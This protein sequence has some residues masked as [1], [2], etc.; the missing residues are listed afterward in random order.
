[1]GIGGGLKPGR[2]RGEKTHPGPGLSVGRSNSRPLDRRFSRGNGSPYDLRTEEGVF[3]LGIQ[4]AENV[5]ALSRKSAAASSISRKN[6]SAAAVSAS[7]VFSRRTN[8]ALAD[9][10]GLSL[11][12][13][14][15]NAS[16]ALKGLLTSRCPHQRTDE[17]TDEI[18]GSKRLCENRHSTP[19]S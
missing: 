1:M 15:M 5:L 14:L 6:S 16:Q 17:S 9:D 10:T 7:L 4:V 12:E 2:A 11:E 13:L 19:S 18:G 3:G 8:E